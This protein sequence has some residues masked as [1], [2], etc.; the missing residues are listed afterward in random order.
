MTDT[1]FDLLI[2]AATLKACLADVVVVDCRFSLVDEAAGE[3]AYRAGH[4]PGA[5][6]LHLNRDL[7]APLG[8]HGGRHPLPDAQ[9]FCDRL[10]QLGVGRDT[11]VV[12][13]CDSRFAFSSRL[14]WM[15]QALGYTRVQLLDGGYPSWVANGGEESTEDAAREPVEP[16]RADAYA[17]RLDIDGMR[18]AQGEGALLVDSREERR[19]L[20]LEEP[21]DPVAGHIPGA[22]NYP[23]QGVSDESGRALAADA[24]QRRWQD[25]ESDQELVVY[26][27]SGVTACVNLLS[28]RLAGREGAR[29]YA[30]SWSDWCSYL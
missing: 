6:Y 3:A 17:G 29:L 1:Q 12:A 4:I 25:I 14:W 10:A 22:L 15:M 28:L 30:G 19:Y 7:S 16:H 20:G 26:C 18:E 27:G 11:P 8:E 23:W 21:I 24:Q 5:H 9:A 2:D 13:Y